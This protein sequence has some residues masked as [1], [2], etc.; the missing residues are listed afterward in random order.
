M[1]KLIRK[2]ISFRTGIVLFIIGS[3]FLFLNYNFRR[4]KLKDISAYVVIVERGF[5]SE[6]ISSSGEISAIRLINISPQKQ[7]FIKTLEV[8][9]GDYVIEG[10][11]LATLDDS[12]FLYK[13]EELKLQLEKNEND[14]IRREFLFKEGAISEED[15]EESRNKYQISLAKFND[16][17]TEKNF[18]VVTAPFSGMITNQFADIGTYVAPSSNFSSDGN[19]RNF[20]FELS[21]GIEVVARVPE[22]DIGR[23]KVGQEAIVQVEAYPSKEYL[24]Q[25]ISIS[26][27]AIKDNNV[28]SFEV[29]LQFN[30]LHEEI[31]IGM[32]A[33]LE[34]IVKEN[35]EKVLVPTVSIVT[36]N[37]KKGILIVDENNMPLFKEIEIGISSGSQTSIITGLKEGEKIFINIP[38]WSDWE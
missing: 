27:R 9:E 29:T 16:A 31:R 14:L 21:E 18:Y 20:I 24:A 5:L 7:G 11:V 25:I 38:P 4:N 36:Q 34:F 22:S 2:N 23:I 33:D 8:K 26:P 19:A 13:L 15:L 32:T 28:T 35:E 17:E 30:E 3:L 6:N 12:N 1:L 37:G 10:Q